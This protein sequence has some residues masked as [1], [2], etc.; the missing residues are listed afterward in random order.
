MTTGRINQV[1]FAE[2]VGAGRTL[3][4]SAAPGCL[5]LYAAGGKG[6]VG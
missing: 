1:R 4:S 5:K 2:R 3:L 6:P